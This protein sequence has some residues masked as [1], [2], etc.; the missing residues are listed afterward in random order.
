MGSKPLVPM[1]RFRE[2]QDAPDWEERQL[3]DLL[4]ITSSK[5]VHESDW[6]SQGVPFYRARELVALNNG[7]PITPLC[8]SEELYQRNAQATGEISDGDLLVTGVGSIGV[9]YL[10]KK[11]DRFYFKDGNIVWLK[12]TAQKVN[13]SFLYQLFLSNPVQTQIKKTTSAKLP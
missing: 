10:V 13:G 7:E 5:R 2:F 4:Q 8:I 12:N 9:P 3:G 6:T 11:N 1:L